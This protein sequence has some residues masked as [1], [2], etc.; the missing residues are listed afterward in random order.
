[1]KYEIDQSQGVL[2]VRYEM[3]E[4]QLI[5]SVTKWLSSAL[6]VFFEKYDVY[7]IFDVEHSKAL[8]NVF[9]KVVFSATGSFEYIYKKRYY[10]SNFDTLYLEKGAFKKLCL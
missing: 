10:F 5:L 6:T 2:S 3:E 1:M 8:R 9:A 7:M 4:L